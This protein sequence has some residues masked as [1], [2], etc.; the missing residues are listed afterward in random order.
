MSHPVFG[1]RSPFWLRDPRTR[2]EVGDV[3]QAKGKRYDIVGTIW[4][5]D[6]DACEVLLHVY[7]IGVDAAPFRRYRMPV[8]RYVALVERFDVVQTGL[9]YVNK[10]KPTYE[11]ISA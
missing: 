3:L 5:I 8:A 10:P 9:S 4:D 7:D 11:E 6:P 1:N 2:P